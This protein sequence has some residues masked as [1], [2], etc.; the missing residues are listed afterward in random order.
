MKIN[1]QFE[2]IES[3]ERKKGKCS[4]NLKKGVLSWESEDEGEMEKQ[5]KRRR[6]EKGGKKLMKKKRRINEEGKKTKRKNGN[7]K[8]KKKQRSRRNEEEEKKVGKKNKIRNTLK[9]YPPQ[10]PQPSIFFSSI[11]TTRN[12][13]PS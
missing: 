13:W 9:P 1:W 3:E 8:M 7:L 5:K 11:I 4:D 6:R 2:E 12:N 10:L